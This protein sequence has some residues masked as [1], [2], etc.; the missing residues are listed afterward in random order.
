MST[1]STFLSDGPAK[2]EHLALHRAPILLRVVHSHARGWDALDELG[3]TPTPDETIYVYVL[4]GEPSACFVDGRD[5]KTGRRLGELRMVGTYAVAAEQP[6]DGT[7]RD[8]A[9]WR[10]W[11]AANQDRLV[12]AW[13]KG[14]T[15]MP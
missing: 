7:L 12:P 8:T 2:G 14:N 4:Q 15:V 11:C 1:F 5:P 9:A 13:A 10:S 6:D 3:D